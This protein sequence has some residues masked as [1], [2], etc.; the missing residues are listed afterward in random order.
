MTDDVNPKQRNE[1]VGS[2][3]GLEP[4]CHVPS[5]HRSEDDE[6]QQLR[7]GLCGVQV[8]HDCISEIGRFRAGDVEIGAATPRLPEPMRRSNRVFRKKVW[9]SAPVTC[10]AI[11]ALSKRESR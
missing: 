3:E 7:T 10:S 9:D 8:V 11:S 4:G 2:P 6:A 1:R 5:R